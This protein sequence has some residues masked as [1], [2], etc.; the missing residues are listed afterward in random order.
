MWKQKKFLRFYIFADLFFAHLISTSLWITWARWSIC[1]PATIFRWIFVN[2]PPES[3]GEKMCKTNKRAIKNDKNRNWLPF[4]TISFFF[5]FNF[6][7]INKC[8]RFVCELAGFLLVNFKWDEIRPAGRTSF[9]SLL[10]YWRATWVEFM[11]CGFILSI[12]F[13]VKCKHRKTLIR[14]Q[15]HLNFSFI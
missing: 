9:N 10:A 12:G 7:W 6:Y 1:L 2:K 14:F 13:I 8:F 4:P 11:E 15:P 5:W 3:K